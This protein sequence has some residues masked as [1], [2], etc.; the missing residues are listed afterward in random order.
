MNGQP[1]DEHTFPGFPF[2]LVPAA[3]D[4][5]LTGRRVGRSI[6]NHRNDLCKVLRVTKVQD[7]QRAAEARVVS[8]AL[9]KTG[10]HHLALQVDDFSVLAAMFRHLFRRT[11]IEY[12]VTL[13]R[14]RFRAR[15][16]VI[17]R[18]NVCVEEQQIGDGNGFMR[19]GAITTAEQCGRKEHQGWDQFH[20]QDST[21]LLSRRKT[22]ASMAG[23][24]F[25]DG[26]RLL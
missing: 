25:R 2:V 15:Q 9:D 18:D 20:R 19:V 17:D 14:D 22:G 21:H 11:H 7:H 23:R 4:D 6:C 3:P 8:V 16:C 12:E 5:P 13:D 24:Q 26:D 1:L 10:D